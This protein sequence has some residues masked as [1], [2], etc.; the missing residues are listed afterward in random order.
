MHETFL[1]INLD[2]MTA[3]TGSEEGRQISKHSRHCSRHTIFIGVSVPSLDDREIEMGDK[4]SNFGTSDT[5]F[6]TSPPESVHH[7]TRLTRHQYRDR[8][9][10]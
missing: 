3:S 2:L 7:L 4:V 8:S 5:I 1:D 10:F 6:L 9:G